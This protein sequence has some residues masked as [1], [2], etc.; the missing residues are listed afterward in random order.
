[1]REDAA[2]DGGESMVKVNTA[3]RE[4]IV[5]SRLIIF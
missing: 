2:E 5:L 3:Q 4:T 1:L